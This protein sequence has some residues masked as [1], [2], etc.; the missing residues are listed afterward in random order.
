MIESGRAR[1]MSLAVL[2]EGGLVFVALGLGWLFR[3]D[4]LG[5]LRPSA[6]A[7]VAGLVAAVPPFVLLL[8]TERI[9]FGPLERIKEL[10]LETLGPS[11]AACKWYDVVLLATLAGFGEE[12]LFRGVVQVLIERWAAGW[13]TSGDWSWAAGLIL[14]NV[15][16][17][18]LHFIT[19]TYA[20]LAGLMGVYFGLLLNVTG[21]HSLLAPILAHGLYDYL[22]FLVLIRATASSRPVGPDRH[23]SAGAA[24]NQTDERRS[25]IDEGNPKP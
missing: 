9:R 16:F 6:A 22:A 2:F 14:S 20:V 1:F 24:S 18:L 5:G 13:T 4:V 10:V 21:S 17:G 12:L 23:A 7:A 19:P 11:L 3:I 15:I 8:A 25:A